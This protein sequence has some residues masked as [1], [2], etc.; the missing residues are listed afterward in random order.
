MVKTI[1]DFDV[2]QLLGRG[3]FATVFRAHRRHDGLDVAIKIIEKSK[4]INEDARNRIHNEISIHSLLHHKFVVKFIDHFE[5][6]EHIYI[7]MELCL[8]GNLYQYLKKKGTL[9]IQLSSVII[10]QILET[11]QYLHNNGII[12]RD[13]KLSNILLSSST[14][15]IKICDFGLAVK[16]CHPGKSLFLFI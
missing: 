14:N 15:K 16:I 2:G 12:H 10:F 7:V 8:Y 11:V 13:L 1:N 3:G 4:I 5:D 6:D 9:S